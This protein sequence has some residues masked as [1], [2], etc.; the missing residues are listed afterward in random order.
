MNNFNLDQFL[1]PYIDVL[2][3]TGVSR[4]NYYRYIIE[5]LI[6][7][8]KPITVVETGTM[9]E[10]LERNQGAFTLIFADLI[11]NHTG[12]KL[13]TIDISE[14]H[15]NNCKNNTKDFS[16]VID[17]IISDSV[18][19]LKSLT[20]EEV[21]QIDFIYFD[22]YDLNLVDPAPSQLHHY[23]ELDAVYSRLK[24]NT[25]IAVDDNYSPETWVD[26]LTWSGGEFIGS[27]KL[28]ISD[29]SPYRILG[30][31]TLIDCFLI[32]NGWER[33]NYAYG[34]GGG[35][36]IGYEKNN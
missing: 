25:S 17:Y 8:N 1:S 12:G 31:G 19:Y 30:K 14:E 7:L 36:L 35:Q 9:W 13:I 33:L 3:Q 24:P 29:I 28:H 10:P 5:K 22:S 26:W 21:Q 18:T 20:D 16:D 4:L 32:D 11:K 6:N 15:M 2:N 27:E 34:H 23:R